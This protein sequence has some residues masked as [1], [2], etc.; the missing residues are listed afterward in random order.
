MILSDT[1]IRK[2][3]NAGKIEISDFNQSNLGSNSYDLSLGGSLLVYSEKELDAKKENEFV[4]FE[5]PEPEGYVL[6]PG[7]LYLGVTKERTRVRGFAP[8]IEGKSSIGRLGM[9]VHIT[10]GVGDIGFNGHWTLEITVVKPLRV[11]AGMPVAQIMFLLPLGDCTVPYSLKPSAK[12][13]NQE[14]IPM[15]SMMWK[16]FLK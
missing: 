5:I 1:D 7:E 14:N 11:Y 8:F 13:Q 15:P 12:Y 2:Q 6:Q 10:A 3:I 9:S 4:R 16:N